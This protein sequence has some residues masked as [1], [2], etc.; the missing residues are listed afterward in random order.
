M[1]LFLTAEK[2]SKPKGA[3]SGNTGWKSPSNIALIKYWGKKD[4]Q[5]PQNPSVS[6]TLEQAFTKTTIAWQ[7]NQN[8][9]LSVSLRFEGYSNPKFAEKIENF[10]RSIVV[11]FPFLENTQFQITTSNTFPHSTGIASSASSMS[12]FCLGLTEIIAQ[13]SGEN[14]DEATFYKRASYLSRL[15]SGSASRSVYPIAAVWGS[16]RA[17]KDSSDLFA[18]P[19][20]EISNFF[21]NFADAILIVDSTE[22]KVSSRAGHSLMVGNPYA[23]VRYSQAKENLDQLLEIMKGDDFESFANIVEEE[24][25]TLHALMMTSRPSYVLMKPNSLLIIEKIKK[26]REQIG[27]KMCFTL[28]AGPNIHLLYPL[29][30]S[31]KVKNFINEEL[32]L[33]LPDVKVLFDKVGKGPEKLN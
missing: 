27:I 4:V 20:A 10:L 24:A 30:E 19:F 5:I 11:D 33:L 1:T 31:E 14:T 21:S 32:C 22:K 13:V 15:A 16:T 9:K 23:E 18:T 8:V 29:N 7:Y 26:A 3:N 12:A 25:L 2:Y 6:Y 28:D 17:Q